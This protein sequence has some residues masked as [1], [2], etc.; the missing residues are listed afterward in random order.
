M[1]RLQFFYAPYPGDVTPQ[2]MALAAAINTMNGKHFEFVGI[3]DTGADQSS[4]SADLLEK[5]DVDP[6]YLTEAEI[7]AVGGRVPA[8]ACDF[9][10]VGLIDMSSG[11]Y[12]FPNQQDPVP[13]HFSRGPFSLIGRQSLLDHCV[14]TFDGPRKIVTLDF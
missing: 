9:I 13:L 3:L 8:L 7:G 2:P 10:R 4:L 14:A 11:K 1:P 6:R 5:L 12:I